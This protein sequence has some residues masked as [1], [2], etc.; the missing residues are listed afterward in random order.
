MKAQPPAPADVERFAALVRQ[1]LGLQFDA[2]RREP[3]ADVLV[4]RMAAL[5]TDRA[6]ALCARVAAG[7]RDELRALA[8]RLTVGETY[9]FRN[10]EQLRALGEAILPERLRAA[11]G[12][13]LRLLSAGCASGEEPLSLAMVA[14]EALGPAPPVSVLGIDVNPA[15]LLRAQRGRY[16]AWSLRQTPSALR[17]RWFHPAGREFMV[18][19]AVRGLCTFEE[20][21]L[22]DADAPWAAAGSFD[23]VFCRNVLMY[24][25]VDTARAVVARLAHALVPGGALFLGHAETLRNLSTTFHL[26]HGYDTFYYR[27]KDADE[28]AEAASGGE[29][30]QVAWFDAI[31]RASA[32]IAAL[33]RRDDAAAPQAGDGGAWP[34]AAPHAAMTN[35]AVAPAERTT[36]PTLV[37][38]GT[39]A[40]ALAGP[41]ELLRSERF[42]DAL[43]AFDALP[44][45]ARDGTEAQLL[46]AVLLTNHG[47]YGAA[48]DV[49]GALLRRD[50][51]SAGAR[52]VMALLSEQAGAVDEALDHDR[53]AVYLDPQFAMPRLHLG[54]L[55]R[56]AGDRDRAVA[57]LEL[58][59]GLL[60][61]EEPARLLLFGGGFSRQGLLTLCRAELRA[62]RGR[63]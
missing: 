40:T 33:T 37:A 51:L 17:E 26:C 43:A 29:G 24:F 44:A 38:T 55:L 48:R 39:S 13:P 21:N 32:R 50:E 6:E 52:Y 25:D 19:D 60:E 41:L 63:P 46:H 2:G 61:R 3:L 12:R 16:S 53:F 7:R 1:R 4:E 22:V 45:A 57:E 36:A 8:E 47:D 14:L 49:C 5:G 18:D 15:A 34:G 62:G 58:A 11:G 23:V 20:R 31:G 42:A 9:F 27:R 28:H 10:A 56:R 30:A 35:A 59:E 54:V